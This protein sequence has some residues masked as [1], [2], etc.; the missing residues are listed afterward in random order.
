LDV[1]HF[2]PVRRFIECGRPPREAHALKN[3][4]SVC[5]THHPDAGGQT[6]NPRNES[7]ETELEKLRYRY[8]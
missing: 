7:P 3:L 5:W 8:R 6:V 4:V 1:H 2:V